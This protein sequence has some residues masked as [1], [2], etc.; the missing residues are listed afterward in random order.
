M[1]NLERLEREIAALSSAELGEFRRWYAEFDAAALDRQLDADARSGGPIAS[2]TKRSPI[3]VPGARGR[4]E[5]SCMTA[6][7]GRRGDEESDRGHRY[8]VAI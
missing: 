2:P 3:I 7:L 4:F 8:T 6:L 1:T 5:A